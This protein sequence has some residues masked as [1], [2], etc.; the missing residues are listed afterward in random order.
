MIKRLKQKQ[1]KQEKERLDFER[2]IANVKELMNTKP[3][4]ELDKKKGWGVFK[5][6]EKRM[7]LFKLQS[8]N[9]VFIT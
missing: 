4:Q 5:D 3:N 7:K 1:E 2:E 6:K 8:S 9:N